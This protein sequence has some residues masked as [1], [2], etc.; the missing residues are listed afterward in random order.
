MLVIDITSAKS[1]AIVHILYLCAYQQSATFKCS[2]VH[3]FDHTIYH[4]V[5]NVPHNSANHCALL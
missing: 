2:T 5:H 1:K 3:G 4:D